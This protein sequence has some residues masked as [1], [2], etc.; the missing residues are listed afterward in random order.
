M[1]VAG[2][3]SQPVLYWLDVAEVRVDRTHAC[4]CQ[5]SVLHLGE[6]AVEYS[7]RSSGRPCLYR[8]LKHL[9]CGWVAPV[10]P[11]LNLCENG[12]Q[13]LGGIVGGAW[14]IVNLP[15]GGCEISGFGV[16]G[17]TI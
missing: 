14:H 11:R 15:A 13:T 2:L 17:A 9:S 10:T 7:N 16:V 6:K 8:V 1:A 5:H 3:A 4:Q 12:V